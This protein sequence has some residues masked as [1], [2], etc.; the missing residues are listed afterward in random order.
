MKTSNNASWKKAKTL[1]KCTL[2]AAALAGS[3][4]AV[5]AAELTITVSNI[6]QATGN[7]T[8]RIY[9]TDSEWLSQKEDGSKAAEVVD[10]AAIELS[11]NGTAEITRTF[12]LPEG[13]YA[14]SA[15]HDVNNNGK[16]DTDWRGVPKEPTGNSGFGERR[17]GPPK[18]ET[19]KFELGGE[20]MARSIR[21]NSY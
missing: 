18:F 1:F 5:K 2:L 10:L 19:S 15:I 7:L 20:G 21:L 12:Q 14:A 3:A 13:T 9:G 17:D 11:A 16:L 8:I 4:S 6:K